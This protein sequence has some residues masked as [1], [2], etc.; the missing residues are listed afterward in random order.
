MY[1][2]KGGFRTAA[3][4][5]MERFVIIVNG[6]QRL[7]IITKHSILDI[8]AALDLP[9]R[10]WSCGTFYPVSL[11]RFPRGTENRI[12]TSWKWFNIEVYTRFNIEIYTSLHGFILNW[13]VLNFLDFYENVPCK[14]KKVRKNCFDKQEKPWT[15]LEIFR[16]KPKNFKVIWA[17]SGHSKPKIFYVGRHFFETLAPPTI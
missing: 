15:Y 14:K 13:T 9:L 3:T 8:A 17:V 11:N 1:R 12:R 7:T 5:K 6:F 2:T 4:S 10:T 16:N